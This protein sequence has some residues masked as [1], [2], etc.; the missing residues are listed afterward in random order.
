MLFRMSGGVKQKVT[1]LDKGGGPHICIIPSS[2]YKILCSLFVFLFN[3]KKGRI[4]DMVCANIDIGTY[5][6]TMDKNTE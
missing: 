2:N 5:I 6:P 4:G 3:D 1:L